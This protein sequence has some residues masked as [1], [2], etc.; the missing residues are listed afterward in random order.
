MNQTYS[1]LRSKTFWLLVL[2]AFIPVANAIVPT[3]PMGVQDAASV[4]L[5]IAAI[6]THSL[7][8]KSVGATN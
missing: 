2:A 6:Y 1:L 3:L 8:A 5:S 4:L 7:T